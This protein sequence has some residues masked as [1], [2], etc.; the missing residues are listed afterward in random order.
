MMVVNVPEKSNLSLKCTC[1]CSLPK[2]GAYLG[3]RLAGEPR[4]PLVAT[5]GNLLVALVYLPY[6]PLPLKGFSPSIHPLIRII[7][8]LPTFP[9]FCILFNITLL[10]ARISARPKWSH[11]ES[12]PG[13]SASCRSSVPLGPTYNCRARRK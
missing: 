12:L 6:P 2:S 10:G 13:A 1:R 7:Y 4:F 11:H 5:L 9:I 3:A 8:D